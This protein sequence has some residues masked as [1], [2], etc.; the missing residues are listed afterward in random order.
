LGSVGA[1][2]CNTAVHVVVL[3]DT[4]VRSGAPRRL[5]PPAYDEV[6]RADL[7]LHCGDVVSLDF[8]E[9][10]GK[11]APVHAV[12]GNN[13]IGLADLLPTEKVVDLDG[14]AVGMVHDAGPSRRRSERLRA[15][16]PS[17]DVVVFGHSHIPVNEIVDGQLLFNP[18]SATQRRRQPHRTLGV[19][20]IR[21]GSV[22]KH[23]IRVVDD[24]VT[25]STDGP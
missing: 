13:D 17:C 4:H 14:V 10:L 8:L 18:G 25:M 2:D 12:L 22:A 19:L 3:A 16:F 23:E 6:A 11:Y 15:R 5:T 9:E 21:D 24:G 20:D 1:N 7:V